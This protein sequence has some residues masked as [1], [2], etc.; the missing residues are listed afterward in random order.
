MSVPNYDVMLER[1]INDSNLNDDDRALAKD[2][3][4]Q[5]RKNARNCK[6][7]EIDSLTIELE[8]VLKICQITYSPLFYRGCIYHWR[9]G[10]C[11]TKCF[12]QER[13]IYLTS[14]IKILLHAVW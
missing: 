4:K 8:K 14:I 13:N 3:V 7:R 11:G 10:A 12:E 6:I 9:S 2:I 1:D 5:I